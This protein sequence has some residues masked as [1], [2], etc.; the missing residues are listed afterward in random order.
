MSHIIITA[1]LSVPHTNEAETTV[2]GYRIPKDT[3]IHS[4]IYSSHMDP[5]Y[6]DNPHKFNPER[7]LQDGKIKRNKAFMPFGIGKCQNR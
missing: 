7:F 6:W 3:I 2:R 5:L 4:N 1:E